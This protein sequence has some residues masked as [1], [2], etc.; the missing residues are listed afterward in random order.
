MQKKNKS[1]LRGLF[2]IEKVA[3]CNHQLNAIIFTIACDSRKEG[4]IVDICDDNNF[5][6]LF[7]P[8]Y[9]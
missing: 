8:K 3:R 2:F 9:K 5:G 4:P 1:T 6:R 7:M